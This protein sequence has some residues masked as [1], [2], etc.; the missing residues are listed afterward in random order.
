MTL[1]DAIGPMIFLS[2][3][4]L[5][6]LEAAFPARAYPARRLWRLRGWL[7]LVLMGGLATALPLLLPAQWLAAHRLV[8]MR[9]GK[10]VR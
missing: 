10:V 7:F 5:M 1:E 9:D 4:A 3:G 2:Y 6:A 8:E